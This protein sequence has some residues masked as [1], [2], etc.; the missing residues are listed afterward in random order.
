MFNNELLFCLNFSESDNELHL[1][2]PSI[3]TINDNH[4]IAKHQEINLDDIQ[5]DIEM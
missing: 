3:S 1:S 4:R 2:L 5:S